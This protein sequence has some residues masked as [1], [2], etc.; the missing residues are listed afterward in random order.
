MKQFQFH[1]QSISCGW[2]DVEMQI[3]DKQLSYIGSNPLSTFIEA[4]LCFKNE[5]DKSCIQWQ[6]EPGILQIDLS[7]QDKDQLRL[8][9]CEKD[10][11]AICQEW[12]E[13]V[14][15]ADFLDSVIAEGFRVLKSLGIRG[16]RTSWQNDEEFPLGALLEI[17]GKADDEYYVGACCSNLP[18]EIGCMTDYVE[19]LESEEEKRYRQCTVYYES[20]Q[21]QCCGEPFAVGDQVIWTCSVS[22]EIKNAHGFIIDFEE[23]HHGLS[24]HTISGTIRKIIAEYSE[25]PK[26]ERVVYY[27]KAS[28][29]QRA[30]QKAD[31]YEDGCK[32]DEFS[33][34][35]FWG[36]IVT[37][38]DVVVKPLVMN[39]FGKINNL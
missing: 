4:C 8:D 11:E 19:L 37:L 23:D 1:V 16:F 38:E 28:V 36:Y 6:D 17:S 10:E 7:L 22:S 29:I 5:R 15:Y 24:T 13:V 2:C 12:H 33:D 26:G 9:I 34:R 14:P 20:W 35:T 32:S 21:I 25:F 39:N 30:I 31:G 3:N 18:K 27:H